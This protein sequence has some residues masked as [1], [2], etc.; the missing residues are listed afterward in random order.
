MDPLGILGLL[1]L[2]ALWWGVSS[3]RARVPPVLPSPGEVARTIAE[4]LFSSPYLANYHLGD[5]G[6][7]ASLVYTASNVLIALVISCVLG[8]S[9]GFITARGGFFAPDS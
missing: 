9:L 2:I 5:G 3:L 8:I 1:L 4:N 7:L 6:L